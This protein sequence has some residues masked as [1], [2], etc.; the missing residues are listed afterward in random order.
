MPSSVLKNMI[1]ISIILKL[2]P[3]NPW[4]FGGEMVGYTKRIREDGSS[5]IVDIIWVEEYLMK[6]GGKLEGGKRIGV[7]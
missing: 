1:P 7:I 6:I 5:G 3:R 2:T 4:L